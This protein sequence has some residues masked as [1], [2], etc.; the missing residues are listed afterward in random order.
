MIHKKFH[1][2]WIALILILWSTNITLGQFTER[3]QEH[4]NTGVLME[5]LVFGATIV[6]IIMALLGLV[7]VM[8]VML[9]V[10][11]IRFLE[12]QGIEVAEKVGLSKPSVP[13]WKRLY[14]RATQ[15]VPLEK[16]K[17]I[18]F[19][20]E[21]DGIRELDNSL[22][23]WWVA[24]F[25]ITIAFAAIYWGYYHVFDYGRNQAA[26]YTYELER[27]ETAVKAFLATQANAVDE[28]NVVVMEDEMELVF[29][30]TIYE[31]NCAVCHGQLGEGGV[32]PNFA[33]PYWLHGGDIKDLF[34]TIKYG[35]P[36]KGMTAW[37]SIL[38]PADIQKVASYILTFQGTQPPN[39]KEPQG[40]LYE[41][42]KAVQDSSSV[43]TEEQLSL[44]N[45]A[46]N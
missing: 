6:I 10:Q 9:Q 24:M 18:L 12:E 4:P 26:E 29:G 46:I 8:N 20:H 16:E 17:D 34:R 25:Y 2:Y 19:D 5:H 42:E 33:D 23:P 44:S 39:A 37:K 32:G 21:Y 14:E 45:N 41:P 13:L 35:V 27:A 43:D 15:L 36:E 31:T 40:E 38:K 7:H 28:T 3:T 11:K 22:P 1:K 30:K